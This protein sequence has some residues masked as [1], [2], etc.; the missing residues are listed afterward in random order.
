MLVFHCFG[1]L[2]SIYCCISLFNLATDYSG[3]EPAY[4]SECK[5]YAIWKSAFL[6]HIIFFFM[7]LSFAVGT[8]DTFLNEDD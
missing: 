1:A 8:C 6:C 7:A 2:C 4:K 5:P 3:L